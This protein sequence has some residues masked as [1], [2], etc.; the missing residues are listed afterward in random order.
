MTDTTRSALIAALDEVGRR[1]AA[2]L[3]EVEDALAEVA[4]EESAARNALE[5]AQRRIVALRFVREE[6]AERRAQL[7]ADD[8]V[9]E[10]AAIREGLLSDRETVLARA[11]ALRDAAARREED[12]AARL[13]AEPDLAAALGEVSRF[14]EMQGEL[15]RMPASYRQALQ[16]RYDRARR[17]LAPLAARLDAPPAALDVP[18]A[19]VGVVL[20][21][22]PPQGR[23]EALVLVLPVPFAVHRE[24][25]SRP[26]DLA[27][28]LTYRTMAGVFMLLTAVGAADAPLQYL[29]VHG[30]LAVQV[31]LG[32]ADVGADLRDRAVERLTMAWEDAPELETACLEVYLVHLRPDLL[33]EA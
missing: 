18:A 27:T 7:L 14:R 19:G 11:R 13:A 2:T 15:D 20:A 16:E 1:R 10:R 33:E 23:P 26:E 22:E 9:A 21:V 8:L 5:E 30:N 17:R 25:A 29:P 32:D 24:W 3:R 12:A 6:Y 31:W 28:L 4:R